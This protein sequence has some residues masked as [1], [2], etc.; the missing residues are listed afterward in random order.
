[1]QFDLLAPSRLE[2][3][4]HSKQ[5]QNVEQTFSQCHDIDSRLE[6]YLKIM[7]AVSQ[8]ELGSH[9]SEVLQNI[10][11]LTIKHTDKR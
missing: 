9:A 10:L 7:S 1:M 2:P 3:N 6:Q 4:G 8:R 5:A 11:I